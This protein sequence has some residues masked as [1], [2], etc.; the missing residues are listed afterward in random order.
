MTASKARLERQYRRLLRCFP[1]SWRQ[2]REE[3]V[4]SLLMEQAAAEQRST[5]GVRAAVD[6]IGHGIEAR[7]DTALRWL[8]WRLREQ[9]AMAALVVAAGLSLVMLVGEVVGAHY[10]PP[11]DEISNYGLYFI[12]GPFLTIGVGMYFG[13]MTAALLCVV[14]RAASPPPSVATWSPARRCSKT[15]SNGSPAPRCVTTRGRS[16]SSVW[17]ADSWVTHAARWLQAPI[18]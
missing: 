2:H 15:L 4:I 1:R 9:V 8:P 5:V 6:L 18:S 12:S 11:A 10:R 7:I 17:L 16:S 3:E 13:Y 14:G